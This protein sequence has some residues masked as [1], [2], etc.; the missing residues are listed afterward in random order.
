[1]QE[2]VV[3]ILN[4]ISR[5][6]AGGGV[7]ESYIENFIC[8]NQVET[9]ITILTKSLELERGKSMERNG[10]EGKHLCVYL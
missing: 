6:A 4:R 7:P 3:Q 5:G 1:M 2:A 8:Q 9:F 10:K